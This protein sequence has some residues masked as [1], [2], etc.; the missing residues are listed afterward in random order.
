MEKENKKGRSVVNLFDIALLLVALALGA[1]LYL[2][3]RETNV[4]GQDVPVISA[5]KADI[6][7]TIEITSLTE[8][9]AA[10]FKAGD[11]LIDVEKKY[12]LGTVESVEVG[13][14]RR[15]VTDFDSLK[16]VRAEEPGRVTVLLT[17]TAEAVIEERNIT[18]DGG[19]VIK[20]GRTVLGK[21]PGCV[22][23]APVVAIE[24]VEI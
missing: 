5:K 9:T 18:V 14:S 11:P 6:R 8:D 7:Y 24:R 17:V 19:Y 16:R 1:L 15:L 3:S 23:S 10:Q 20:V 12:I 22:F 4:P 21:V 13:P 2:G